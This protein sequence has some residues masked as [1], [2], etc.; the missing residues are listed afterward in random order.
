M[1]ITVSII[2]SCIL[3]L[4]PCL[5]FLHAGNS[6]DTPKFRGEKYFPFYLRKDK[7]LKENAGGQD[8]VLNEP[9]EW[10]AKCNTRD[11][12]KGRFFFFPFIL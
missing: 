2:C 5:L 1:F 10:Y 4:T 3:L 6:K 11:R 12:N 7:V 8:R 9:W